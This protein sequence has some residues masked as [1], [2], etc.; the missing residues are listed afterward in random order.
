[1]NRPGDGTPVWKSS[2]LTT[3]WRMSG[4]LT[5]ELWY[6]EDLASPSRERVLKV[7]QVLH[8]VSLFHPVLFCVQSLHYNGAPSL[9]FSDASIS[10]LKQRIFPELQYCTYWLQTGRY[11]SN[12]S[13][14]VHT[15][16]QLL[17]LGS[18]RAAFILRMTVHDVRFDSNQFG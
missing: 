3:F 2:C 10:S 14:T 11:V 7:D 5:M 1:M 4:I 15:L 16:S 6:L 17:W 8:L 18:V 9:C 12:G 13:D